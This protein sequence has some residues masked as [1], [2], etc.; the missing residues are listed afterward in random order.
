VKFHGPDQMPRLADLLALDDAAF[1]KMFAG[2]PVRRAGH[3]R[4]LR[5]VLA[6]VGNS[7]DGALVPAV[8]AH[9]RHDSPLVRSMAVWALSRLL[10][11]AGFAAMRAAHAASETDV[12][13]REEWHQDEAI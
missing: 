7:G 6:A 11:G 1:R 4:F 3:D 2:G 10:N 13:V 8:K 9:L 5:N 12:E